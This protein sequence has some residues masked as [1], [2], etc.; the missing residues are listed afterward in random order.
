[1]SDLFNGARAKAAEA[2]GKAAVNGLKQRG[3]DAVFA[4]TKEEALAEVLR[5]IP[6]GAS[7]G[8]PGSV[9]IREIGAM[10]ALEARGC[11]VSQHWGSMSPEERK[12]RRKAENEADFFLTSANAMTRD[13]RIISI[14]GEGNRVSAMAWGDGTLIFVIGVNKIANS[15]DEALSRAHDSAAPN[16]LRLGLD[17]ACSKTGFCVDCRAESR[18]CRAVLILEAPTMSRKTRVIV[19]G[20]N[21]GY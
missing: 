4:A 9:T 20:E 1:M 13:G 6:E 21:L 7:V 8:V 3:F 5:T 15:L 17:T 16:A 19:T 11:K 18:V 10:E 12:A 2:L 14:D